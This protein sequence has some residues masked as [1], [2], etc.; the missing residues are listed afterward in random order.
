MGYNFIFVW[1]LFIAIIVQNKQ[2]VTLKNE[3]IGVG[4]AVLTFLPIFIFSVYSRTDIGDLA[5]YISQYQA[6]PTDTDGI[7]NYLKNLD[8]SYLFWLT[9]IIINY[10]SGGSVLI[11]RI[12]ITLLQ[13]IPIIF[14]YRKYSNNYLLSI[15]LFVASGI[16]F[17]WMLNGI[18]QFFAAIIIF[19]AT[20][21]MLEKKYIKLICVVLIASLFHQTAI[22]M[23]PVIFIVQGKI[24]NKRTITTIIFIIIFIWIIMNFS[25]VFD[26]IMKN[27]GYSSE[28][29]SNDDGTNPLRVL[30]NSIPV[31]LSFI[32]KD[33]LREADNR[34]INLSVNMSI[35]SFGIY[36]ISM[37]TSG[38]LIG[39]LPIY[40]S[41]YNFILLPYLIKELFEYKSYKI[42]C[43]IL[44]CAYYIYFFVQYL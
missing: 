8:D 30:V 16:Q 34:I 18:R 26:N 36:F 27:M 6:L 37:F 10:F 21:L 15:Y 35:I 14:I 20:P 28:I 23:L 38:I 12:I 1:I 13:C 32:G 9:A 4:I 22:I 29:Y 25:G 24:W 31:I 43:V 41:L 7:I 44:I 3:K 42:M 39:R 2:K 40:M 11:F 33:K 5:V 17:A 19:L